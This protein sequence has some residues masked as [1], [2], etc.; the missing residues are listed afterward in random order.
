M[1][2]KNLLFIFGDQH[3][4]CDL[5]CY[6]NQVIQT[7]NLDSLAREGVLL[8]HAYTNC[9]VCVPARGTLLT[10]RY[11][12]RHGA[13]TNDLPVNP[14]V[15]GIADFLNAAGYETAYIGKWHLGGIPRD[16]YIPENERLGFRYWRGCN[17]NH[18][19]YHA[20][21]DDNENQRHRIDG[22]EPLAQTALAE[23]FIR[24][25]SG[26]KP[27]AM[28]VSYGTPHEPYELVPEEYLQRYPEDIP[29]RDNVRLP[30]M[31][32][33]DRPV[34]RE[35]LKRWYRGYYAHISALDEQI[36]R[37]LKTLEETG[38]RENTI[39]VYTSD[40]GDMLGSQG[41]TNKQL[42]HEESSH[43][44]FLI[45]GPGIIPEC[46]DQLFSLADAAPTMLSLLGVPY[47]GMDGMDCSRI[48]LD[49]KAPGNDSIYMMEY[50]PCHQ[51]FDRGIPEWRAVRNH[52]YLYAATPSYPEELLFDLET[53]PLQLRN[54]AGNP[55]FRPEKE[56]MAV[57]L[58]QWVSKT[59]RFLTWDTFI[60]HYG[61]TKAWNRS[62]AYFGLPILNTENTETEE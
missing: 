7:P 20:W 8:K 14:D 57:L 19:Y 53:D 30:A 16:R 1:A 31:L 22:Y 29:F 44:P 55:A 10:G 2:K 4:F 15:P 33:K 35:T 51:S 56:N 13:V 49:P 3:R 38:L 21:Y 5:G 23:E 28:Y 39:V 34:D 18:D 60:P 50:I 41:M 58:K 52:R 32:A 37:I 6:G 27:W 59:D 12:L 62:Q 42:P 25:Q 24:S 47:E 54:L 40:H 36:G 11:P 46:R 17:C 48:F 43:I 61:L 9:P 26:S 45:A